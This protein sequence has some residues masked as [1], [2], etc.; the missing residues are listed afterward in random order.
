MECHAVNGHSFKSNMNPFQSH[1]TSIVF[2][3]EKGLGEL[4]PYANLI[5]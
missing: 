5:Y 2:V 1:P 3:N 4:H